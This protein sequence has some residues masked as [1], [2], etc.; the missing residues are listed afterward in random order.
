MEW[1]LS[2]KLHINEKSFYAETG[3]DRANLLHINPILVC[4]WQLLVGAATWIPAAMSYF[5]MVCVEL[6]VEN[7]ASRKPA[8]GVLVCCHVPVLW[9]SGRS[10]VGAEW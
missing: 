8:V 3:T 9:R 7:S 5:Q 6:F 1:I 4:L 10:T 2:E